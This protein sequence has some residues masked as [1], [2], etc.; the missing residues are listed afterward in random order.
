MKSSNPAAVTFDYE[1]GAE[2]FM[3][4]G[5]APSGTS[6]STVPRMQS[7]SRSKTCRRNR[8]SLPAS[9]SR[10]RDSTD[11]KYAVS[12]T[13]PSFRSCG[14][15]SDDASRGPAAQGHS[16]NCSDGRG[17]PGAR[18]PMGAPIRNSDLGQTACR[19]AAA[20]LPRSLTTS[21]LTF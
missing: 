7:D 1:A 20:S 16:V 12:M 14:G 8:C 5:T 11:A 21:K 13:V 3:T 18:S 17:R 19:F 10:R 2:L 6:A 4:A 9:K 15:A